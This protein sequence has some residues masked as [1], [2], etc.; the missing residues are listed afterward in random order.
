MF[1]NTQN[2]FIHVMTIIMNGVKY[3]PTEISHMQALDLSYCELCQINILY[4]MLFVDM[5]F[6]HTLA[7]T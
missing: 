6:A 1:V 5:G 2:I 7:W 4:L 3:C